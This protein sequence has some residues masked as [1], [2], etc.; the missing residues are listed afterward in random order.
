MDYKDL[1]SISQELEKWEM[2]INDTLK[3]CQI[4]IDIVEKASLECN[5]ATTI[6]K[7]VEA[8]EE[9]EDDKAESELKTKDTK[10]FSTEV[11]LALIMSKEGGNVK[12]IAKHKKSKSPSKL[13]HKT[14]KHKKTRLGKE[15]NKKIK[16]TDDTRMRKCNWC[17]FTIEG[18][19][20]KSS[21][22]TL[23]NL[24]KVNEHPFGKKCDECEFHTLNSN[25]MKVHIRT[26][27]NTERYI[28]RDC[29]FNT[30]S[31][32]SL[33]IYQ[34]NKHFKESRCRGE[35][36]SCKFCN[37]VFTTRTLATH[38][39]I[40]HPKERT[41]V[42]IDQTG[43]TTYSSIKME[44][45]EKLNCYVINVS[46]NHFGEV[47]FCIIKEQSMGVLNINPNQKKLQNLTTISYVIFKPFIYEARV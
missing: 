39:K 15:L 19:Y 14:L 30:I 12:I 11:D 38:M 5:A 36:I 28:C 3:Q 21:A 27:H 25:N 42:A 24:H 8:T 23:M 31:K 17:N 7:I 29:G 18:I 26:L 43:R 41:N 13:A 45:M 37:T 10:K 9:T 33:K 34:H 2:S 44:N 6:D 22:T 4:D 47:I 1:V 46:L 16:D 40:E 20:S 32:F 35:D